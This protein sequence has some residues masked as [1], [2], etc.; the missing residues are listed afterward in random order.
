MKMLSLYFWIL[1]LMFFVGTALSTASGLRDV[2]DGW[3][4]PTGEIV[5][6]L[7]KQEWVPLAIPMLNDGSGAWVVAGGM[8]L[9]GMPELPVQMA[10]LGLRLGKGASNWVANF[11][12]QRTGSGIFQ[13]DLQTFAFSWN[14]N[15]GLGFCLSRRLT[16]LGSEELDAW[17][18]LAFRVDIPPVHV[19]S[20]R[21]ISQLQ[22]PLGSSH[23]WQ[24]MEPRQSRFKFGVTSG[25][26][27]LATVLDKTSGSGWAAGLEIFIA[28]NQGFGFSVLSDPATGSLGP[29]T[30][31][32][33]DN[34]LIKTSHIVHPELGLTHRITLTAGALGAVT[35]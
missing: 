14:K 1:L 24:I 7:G 27:G 34:L 20:Y 12:W 9:F 10:G 32:V 18:G 5:K 13:S 28:L 35:W 2:S 16:S 23:A 21:I 31:W 25:R 15:W 33:W 3:I 26:L 17:L 19:A 6:L 29:G 22:I 11:Q 8:Q 30:I 4:F